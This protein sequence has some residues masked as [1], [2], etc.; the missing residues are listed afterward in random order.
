MPNLFDIDK[1]FL[2]SK[3]SMKSLPYKVAENIYNC[4]RFL[5]TKDGEKGGIDVIL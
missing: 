1:V 2:W 3:P 5:A 4:R